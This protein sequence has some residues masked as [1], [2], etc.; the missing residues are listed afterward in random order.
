MGAGPDLAEL[1][2]TMEEIKSDIAMLGPIPDS[3]PEMIE[4][5]N[6]LRRNEHLQRSDALKTDLVAKYG[7]YVSS[8]EALL[9]SVFEIQNE[10]RGV[11]HEQSRLISRAGPKPA[12]RGGRRTGK[13]GRSTKPAVRGGRRTGKQGRSTKPAV[14][15]GRR[16]GKQ[17]RS[18]KPAVRG[19]RRT[20]KQGRS[21][22]PAV[23]GGRRT[24]K[25]G[26]STKPAV[27]GGRRT[28]RG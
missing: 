6:L 4:S 18:T 23:R 14:R 9:K 16:T 28:G 26:R 21:T 12:V 2:N 22:K 17:G 10:L 15:G 11:L 5:A 25:Q 20:G 7:A 24:G 27:R 13:Q 1:R 3:V 8:L 19:G